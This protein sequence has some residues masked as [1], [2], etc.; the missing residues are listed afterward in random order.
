MQIEDGFAAISNDVNVRGTMIV[1]INHYAQ[2]KKHID[3]R[4]FIQT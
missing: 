1:R 4:H 3:S 2:A